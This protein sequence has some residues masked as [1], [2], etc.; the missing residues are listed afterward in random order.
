MNFILKRKYFKPNYT[1]GI[2]YL[3]HKRICETMEPPSAHITSK[4][5]TR[6][7]TE[8]KSRGTIAIPTG[9]YRILVTKS[10]KFFKWLPLLWNVPCFKGIRIHAGNKPSDT[11][12]CILPG[13]N[14]RPGYVLGSTSAMSIIM[15][16][17]QSALSAD[18]SVYITI[19]E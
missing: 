9:Q 8:A 15:Q 18:E 16:H 19:K 1:I 10:Y 2:L 13:W 17:I 7:I 12:G 6:R 5:S 11:R 4:S 3:N 14:R